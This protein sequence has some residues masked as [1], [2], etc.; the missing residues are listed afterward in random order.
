[1]LYKDKYTFA[2]CLDG[3]KCFLAVL[4][5]YNLLLFQTFSVI[6]SLLQR[7]RYVTQPDAVY[8]GRSFAVISP[9]MGPT[10]SDIHKSP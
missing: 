4:E 10:I 2:A 9:T 6:H 8:I 7:S 1:M 3:N 5:Y